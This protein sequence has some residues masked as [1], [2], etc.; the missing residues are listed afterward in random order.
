MGEKQN[1]WRKDLE[2]ATVR[3]HA[4]SDRAVADTP[5]DRELLGQ[6]SSG[7]PVDN[8]LGEGEVLQEWRDIGQFSAVLVRIAYR[9]VGLQMKIFS[10][11]RERRDGCMISRVFEV[12]RR[13]RGHTTHRPSRGLA[14][15]FYVSR[16]SR[17]GSITPQDGEVSHGPL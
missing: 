15:I 3:S 14:R 1:S 4:G 17:Q 13:F 12:K 5:G 6:V 2:S 8:R 11:Y 16:F 10:Q 9:F 7:I